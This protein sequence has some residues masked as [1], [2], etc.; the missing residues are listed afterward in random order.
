MYTNVNTPHELTSW[1]RVCDNI[2]L[3]KVPS[4]NAGEIESEIKIYVDKDGKLYYYNNGDKQYLQSTGCCD[5]TFTDRDI[6]SKQNVG[7][8]TVG[9]IVPE[10]STLTEVV[11]QFIGTADW[12]G[13][14]PKAYVYV[15]QFDR[16][17]PADDENSTDLYLYIDKTAKP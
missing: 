15:P 14:H 9:D 1:N 7:N 17:Q 2:D 13:V 10:G 3:I 4:A 5:Q 6:E 16:D 11:D 12:T 8:V